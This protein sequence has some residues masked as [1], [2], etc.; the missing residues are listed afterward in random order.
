MSNWCDCK[1]MISNKSLRVIGKEEKSLNDSFIDHLMKLISNHYFEWIIL[2][3]KLTNNLDT[4]FKKR[5]L[6]LSVKNDVL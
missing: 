5:K 4:C 2:V 3:S 6:T 1:D